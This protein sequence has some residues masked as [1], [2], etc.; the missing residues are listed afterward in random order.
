[1]DLCE[2][3]TT[4]SPPRLDIPD[5]FNAAHDLLERNL[6]AGRADKVVYIDDS[7][8]Y[9]YG[10]LATRVN[11]F[12]TSLRDCGMHM[13]QRILLC[14]Q[15]S[16][17]FPIAFLG[18]I[19]AGVVPIPVNTMLS[20]AD[21]AYM[22]HDSRALM[23]VVSAQLLP[24]FQPILAQSV[25]LKHIL[26]S[27]RADAPAGMRAFNE[28][29][30]A[31]SDA[32]DPAPTS[33][34]EP[35]FWLY[36]SGST[37]APKGTVHVHSSLIETA[38]L[39]AQGTLGLTESDVMLSAAK[40]FFAYGL[41]NSLTFPL[42]TGGTAVLMAERTTPAAISA[43]LR[44]HRPTVFSGVPTL[45]AALLA[46]E[47]LPKA[48]EL[49]LRLCNSAGEALPEQIARRWRERTG[50]D[51]VDGIGSTEML[52]IFISNRPDRIRHGTLGLPV[53]GFDA[54]IVDAEG[55]PVAAGETGDLLVRGPTSA[56]FY[57]NQHARSRATFEGCWTR[58]GDRFRVDANG[59]YVYAGRADDMLKV[60]GI[61]VSPIEVESALIAHPAVQEAAVVGKED[62]DRLIKPIAYVVL[63]HGHPASEALADELKAFV[64]S[65]LAPYKYP[66]WIEFIADLPKTVTGKIQRYKLRAACKSIN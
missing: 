66:R 6:R 20:S 59:D 51:I 28:V 38:A 4:S 30:A 50:V 3:D 62:S 21:Y 5:R 22:L 26:V 55:N 11:R 46:S 44:K 31:S 16:I 15:D 64:K 57:W 42:A 2:I 45:Y 13:E 36:S 49:S 24:Q 14:L 17:D 18:A 37:G 25:F 33:R 52:H 19:K 53:P 43:R 9:T 58:T 1:M 8:E 35:C 63:A 41:G 40:L 10:H 61:Y 54:K 23:L 7:G 56:K 12:A 29:L 39:Y 34:D 47:Q 48:E 60:G 32:F 27:G 65:R